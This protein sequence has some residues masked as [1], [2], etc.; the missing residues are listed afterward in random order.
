MTL[1]NKMRLW[2]DGQ[3]GGLNLPEA[4]QVHFYDPSSGYTYVARKYGRE[5]IDGR[6]VEK[7]IA[8]RMLEHANALIAASYQVKTDAQG[9]VVTDAFGVPALALDANGQPVPVTDESTRMAE[10]TRYVGLLDATRQVG[11]LLGYGPLA[12]TAGGDVSA[13]RQ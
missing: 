1:A 12:G 9:Q 13:P 10:L 11:L 7:G 3:V 2:I 6:S 4:D 5:Q 8:S